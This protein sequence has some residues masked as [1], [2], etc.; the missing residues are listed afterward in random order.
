MEIFHEHT[1][2]FPGTKGGTSRTIKK[3]KYNLQTCL[4]FSS[5]YFTMADISLKAIFSKV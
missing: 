1:T 2:L 3:E 4:V 5:L